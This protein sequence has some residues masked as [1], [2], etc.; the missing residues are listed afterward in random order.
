MAIDWD[1]VEY[2]LAASIRRNQHAH[3]EAAPKLAQT[4][5]GWDVARRMAAENRIVT[6]HGEPIDAFVDGWLTILGHEVTK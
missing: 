5:L 2:S 4:V 3:G 1:A 6:S